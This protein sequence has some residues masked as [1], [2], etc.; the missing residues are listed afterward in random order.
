MLIFWLALSKTE[1]A[2]AWYHL[3][4]RENKRNPSNA[5]WQF[6]VP[7]NDLLAVAQVFPEAR[8]KLWW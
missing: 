7:S 1:S 3:K 8:T 4:S 2:D 5:G 6:V